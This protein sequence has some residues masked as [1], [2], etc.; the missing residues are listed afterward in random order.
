M[1]LIF[2]PGKYLTLFFLSLDIVFAISPDIVEFPKLNVV[3]FLHYSLLC[4]TEFLSVLLRFPVR[5]DWISFLVLTCSS[6]CFTVCFTSFTGHFFFFEM[7]GDSCLECLSITSSKSTP[8]CL[9]KKYSTTSLVTGVS[10]LQFTG[11]K[12]FFF[13]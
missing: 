12:S 5:V 10:N 8:D 3:P 13:N 6:E 4:C 2:A 11:E 7:W 9:S 1:S